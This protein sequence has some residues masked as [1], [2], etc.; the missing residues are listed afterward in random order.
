MND[1]VVILY[2]KKGDKLPI[3][4]FTVD[5]GEPC[6]DAD[7]QVGTSLHTLELNRAE[8]CPLEKGTGL[9]VDPRYTSHDATTGD[10]TEFNL[11]KQEVLVDN[12]VDEIIK[13]P[14]HHPTCQHRQ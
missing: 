3:T 9:Y 8:S 10:I 14:Q 11:F 5:V 1:N 4:T 7:T 2:T 6:M 12:G 13:S